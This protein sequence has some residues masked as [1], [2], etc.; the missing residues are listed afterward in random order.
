MLVLS[1]IFLGENFCSKTK[2]KDIV[3]KDTANRLVHVY[4]IVLEIMLATAMKV[5]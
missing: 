3:T 5:F 1:R 2:S 4:E